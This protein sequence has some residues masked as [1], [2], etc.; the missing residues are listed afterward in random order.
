[1]PRASPPRS[2]LH[3]VEW[4]CELVGTAVVLLV[5]ISAIC[6][7]MAGSSPIGE[8]PHTWRLLLT[9]LVFA[10][11]GSL[12]AVSPLGRRSGAHL[13][14]V[15][16]LAFWTQRKVHWHDLAGYTAAQCVGA[17][18]GTL[19]AHGLWQHTADTVSDGATSPGPGV[20][21]LAA[22]ALEAGM[23]ACLLLAILFMTSHRRTARFTP[24]L[25][26]L[27]IAAFVWRLS[28]F[29]GTSMNPA[30]SLGPALVAPDLGPYWIYIAGPL[31]GTAVA[32]GLFALARNAD[33]L[34]TKLFHDPRYRS[35]MASTLP[36]AGANARDALTLRDGP[37][38]TL[39]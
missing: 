4:L 21:D 19:V 24:L 39:R 8:L 15:V 13:N 26:W 37:R 17:L 7:D 20:Q 27:L 36:I 35:T 38:R 28:A 33:V 23:T 29:T 2:G 18:L 9:G 6:F 3:P 1:M 34:T 14:P 12:V 32:V 16:T 10:G 30:R 31:L 11:T 25:L 5:G 22:V